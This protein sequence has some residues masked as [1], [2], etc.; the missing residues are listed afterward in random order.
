MNF[1][2]NFSTPGDCSLKSIKVYERTHLPSSVRLADFSQR[3]QKK[4][5]LLTTIYLVDAKRRF[6]KHNEQLFVAL[7]LL[8]DNIT[9][10]C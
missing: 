2:S 5:E 8:K 10:S 4:I 1:G 3:R 9:Q 7:S 6:F